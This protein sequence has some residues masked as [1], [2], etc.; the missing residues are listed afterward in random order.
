MCPG[1]PGTAWGGDRSDESLS[2]ARLGQSG[3]AG[4]SRLRQRATG[5]ALRVAESE[6]AMLYGKSVIAG[7][8]DLDKTVKQ[9]E[10]DDV[11]PFLPIEEHATLRQLLTARL[12]ARSGTACG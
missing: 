6:P 5:R 10:L 8:V 2:R 4:V 1:L 11:Q 3:E 12:L 9:L 7:T